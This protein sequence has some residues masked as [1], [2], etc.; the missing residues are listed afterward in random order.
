MQYLFGPLVSARSTTFRL[1]APS[2]TRLAVIMPDRPAVPMQPEADGWWTA[3][4]P[5][6]G[7]GTRYK[8][9]MGDL[10][11]PDPASRRQ[12]GGTSGWSVVCAPLGRPPSPRTRRPWHETVLCEVHVGTVSP[13]GTFLGLAARLEHFRDA[14]YTALELMPISQFPGDRNWGYDGT[15]L[16]AP[17]AAYGSREDLRHLIDRAHALGIAVL[18]DVVYNHFGSHENFI[19]LY[20]PEF[21]DT[22]AHTP[23]G[24]ALAFNQPMVRRFFCENAHLLLAEFDFDGLRLDALHEMK[25]EGSDQC[26]VEL[27]GTARTIK[28]DAMLVVEN[29]NNT[30]CWLERSAAGTPTLFTAQWHDEFQHIFSFLVTGDDKNQYGDGSRDPWSILE[31]GLTHGLIDR[32]GLS[33]PLGPD[34]LVVYL[35]NHDQ[36]GNRAD[37]GRLPDRIGADKLD[38]VHFVL[39]LSPQIPLFFMGEEAHLQTAF[40]YFLDLPASEAQA[41]QSG[42]YRQM[43]ESF[44]QN[45]SEGE[46][47]DPNAQATFVWAKLDWTEFDRPERRAALDRFRSLNQWRRSRVWPLTA[48]R[49]GKAESHRAGTALVI[50]WIF[51]AGVLTMALNTSASACAIPCIITAPPVSTGDT[52]QHGDLLHLGPWSAVAWS[53]ITGNGQ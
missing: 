24:A 38:F 16:F 33:H 42:R 34:A 28:P 11:F 53:T 19:P 39:L 32:S 29:M 13:E 31:H 20:A 41:M 23:W 49:F 6:T 14:G 21:F 37:S 48:S 35:Q 18:L 17:H 27:T 4:V 44:G 8:F 5:H 36:I 52:S 12:E 46:L 26:L 43:R 51:E 3:E 47:P 15:L 1:W 2:A 7:P 45:V 9:R 22:D 50:N 30:A 25:S 10:E 40:P